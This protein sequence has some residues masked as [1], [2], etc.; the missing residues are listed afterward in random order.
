M[1]EER[2]PQ[3]QSA[4]SLSARLASSIGRAAPKSPR[5]ALKPGPIPPP[6][7][8]A[9][10]ARRPLVIFLNFALTAGVVIGA[11]VGGTVLAARFEF[12]QPGASTDAVTLTVR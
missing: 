7:L 3:D 1:V 2:D 6:P 10:A 9:R 5:E 4:D 11:L 8:R 12:Q